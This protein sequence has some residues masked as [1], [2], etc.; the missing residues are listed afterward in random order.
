MAIVPQQPRRLSAFFSPT[1][2]RLPTMTRPPL[3]QSRSDG[4]FFNSQLRAYRGLRKRVDLL[5]RSWSND[6]EQLEQ[7]RQTL[8]QRFAE[9]EVQLLASQSDQKHRALEDWDLERDRSIEYSEREFLT[10]VEHEK[11][12]VEKLKESFVADKQALKKRREDEIA[13]AHKTLEQAKASALHLRES[14][15]TKLENERRYWSS[16]LAELNEWMLLKTGKVMGETGVSIPPNT[17]EEIERTHDLQRLA[18]TVE[19]RKRNLSD[20]LNR[21]RSFAKT[22]GMTFLGL[23]ALGPILSIAGAAVCWWFGVPIL[24]VILLATVGSL[25]LTAILHYMARPLLGRALQRFAPELEGLQAEVREWLAQGSKLAD[26]NYQNDL[27]KSAADHAAT[28]ERVES[29]YRASRENLQRKLERDTEQVRTSQQK[30]R[31]DLVHGRKSQMEASDHKWEPILSSMEERFRQES[32]SHHSGRDGELK[33]L[34]SQFLQSQLRYAHRWKKGA[35]HVADWMDRVNL[36][37][38]ESQPDWNSE[39]FERGDW[40]RD[41]QSLIWR[42]GS[43]PVQDGLAD[44]AAACSPDLRSKGAEWPVAFDLLSHGAIILHASPENESSTDGLISN[45]LLRAITSL[46]A[47][48]MRMTVIDPQGLGKKVSW[49]MA[50]ADVDPGLVGD[51]VWTQPLHIADRLA[52]IARSCEDIIQQSLRDKHANLYEYNLTAGPMALPYRLIVWDQFPFGLDDSSW[53]SLCSILAAGGRCGV[54]VILRLSKSHVWPSFADPK[55]LEE[56]GLHLDLDIV[57]GKER[58]RWMQDDLRHAPVQLAVPPNSEQIKTIMRHQLEHVS[59]LGRLI[60]PFDSIAVPTEERQVTSSAD[61]LAIPLGV[62]ASGRTQLM[63]LGFG[64]AQHVLI[65]GKT[66]SGKSSLLHTMITSAALKYSP[67][68]LRLVL[69]DFKKGVEFQVYSEAK[70]PHA[71]I[72]GIESKREFGVSTLEYIDRIM[73]ARGEAFRSRGV[74]D[75]PSLEKK[76]PEV[77]MPRVLIVIDEFQELFVEDDKISQQASMLMDRIVRQG[78]SFGIH[79]VLASQTLGGAYSLPRTTLAQMAVRIALQCDSSDAMLILGE[80]NT[81]AERLRFSGQAIY[82][83]AGGRIES[84]QGFQVAYIDKETQL[85]FLHQ[86][87]SAPIPHDATTNPMGRC[88]VFEGH[89]PAVWDDQVLERLLQQTARKDD[90]SFPMILGDSVSIDPPIVHWIQR[91]AGRNIAVVGPDEGVAASIL[92][93]TIQGIQWLARNTSKTEMPNVYVLNGARSEDVSLASVIDRCAGFVGAHVIAPRDIEPFFRTCKEELDRRL[94]SSDTKHPVQL[95]C[96]PNI[97]RFRELRKGDEFAYGG[98]ETSPQPDAILSELLKD[99]PTVGMHLWL[100]ADS[101]STLGRWLS[102]QSMR[103]LELRVLM[104]MSANDSNQLIDSNVANKLEP[105]VALIQ[106]EMDGKPC[107]FRP[108]AWKTLPAFR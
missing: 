88:I 53:Q 51:R 72:I 94:Q 49:L 54:G 101:A 17:L 81:A 102:R 40:P 79:L 46:P 95:I 11:R 104:Q 61:S 37:F 10:S 66:G 29:E 87:P 26:Q 9:Q 64:T 100:W 14:I 36:F 107:K 45:L 24:F 27:Q 3:L 7:S 89:K 71:D 5:Q 65:A 76:H 59:Q 47:G 60:V 56:F 99:G 2:D 48:A 19:E 75:L 74:Q 33:A 90:G 73:H 68:E 86:I 96:I 84:N 34:Q 82:N 77:R 50:L 69:L 103:D 55:K 97:S 39:C 35:E 105:H 52:S 108:F 70:V 23:Q 78:R 63:K 106:D 80:D 22:K 91:N 41:P 58:V 12:A 32:A 62:A 16:A 18:K 25:V 67:E 31:W 93:G 1:L 98:G 38:H 43:S 6:T 57:D 30:R 44:A 8:L 20:A 21:V 15:R 85:H 42:I 83:E 13:K 28:L 4:R 92:A